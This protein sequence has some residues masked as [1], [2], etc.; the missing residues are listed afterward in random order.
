MIYYC[1][2]CR[3]PL[4]HKASYYVCDHHTYPTQ[5]IIDEAH[6]TIASAYI[7]RIGPDFRSYIY[8]SFKNLDF[9]ILLPDKSFN[10]PYHSY[11]ECINV[12]HRLIAQKAFL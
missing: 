1:P 2:F 5:I 10:F 8:I 7:D 12:A 3:Q 4:N 6:Q 9:N 11:Q